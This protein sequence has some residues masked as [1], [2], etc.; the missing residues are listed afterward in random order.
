VDHVELAA[1]AQHCAHSYAVVR[2]SDGAHS[3]IRIDQR[4]ATRPVQ[5]SQFTERIGRRVR[6]VREPVVH[7]NDSASVD[8]YAAVARFD[9]YAFAIDINGRQCGTRAHGRGNKHQD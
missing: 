5:A 1:V 4:H 9:R 3:C 6:L 2:Q 8:D 7:S